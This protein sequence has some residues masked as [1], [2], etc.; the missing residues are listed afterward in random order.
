MKK[1][2]IWGWGRAEHHPT[3]KCEASHGSSQRA[4]YFR[5]SLSAVDYGFS[6][7]P[8]KYRREIISCRYIGPLLIFVVR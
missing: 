3:P 2:Y 7:S 8:I 1:G 4:N 6:E 5:R